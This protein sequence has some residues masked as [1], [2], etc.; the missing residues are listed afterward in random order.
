MEFPGHTYLFILTDKKK[1]LDKQLHQNINYF[2]IS[3]EFCSQLARL[4]IFQV[5]LNTNNMDPDQS[6]PQCLLS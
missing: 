5:A 4:H 2:P 6:I 3:H 1:S